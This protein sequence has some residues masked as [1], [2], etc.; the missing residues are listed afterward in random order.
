MIVNRCSDAT[1]REAVPQ[2]A[3][4]ADLDDPVFVGGPVNRTA[5]PCSPSSTILTSA[6]VAVVDGVGFMALEEALEEE[7]AAGAAHARVRRRGRL[8]TGAARATSSSAEDWIIEPADSNDIFTE[9]PEGLWSALLRRMGGQY[10][11]LA[12]MPHDPS[13]N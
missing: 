11:L 3:P 4:V 13:L 10:E 8:G 7:R 12:R 2:L 5:S 6:G 1:V 9:D